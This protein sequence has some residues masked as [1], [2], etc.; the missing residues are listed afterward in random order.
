MWGRRRAPPPREVDPAERRAALK[1]KIEEVGAL[2]EEEK[3]SAASGGSAEGHGDRTVQRT[4]SG[5]A[6][7]TGLS[8]RC[9]VRFCASDSDAAGSGDKGGPVV[10]GSAAGT[11]GNGVKASDAPRDTTAA[12]GSGSGAD[13]VLVLIGTS[14]DA[15]VQGRV[16]RISEI[17]NTAYS[18]VGKHK[19]LD[20]YDVM[21]RLEMGDAGVRANRVLHLAYKGDLL[22]GCASS[23][24]SPGWTGEGCGHW[25]LLAVDPAHQGAGIA[26]ALV[27]AA[28]RRLATTC[29]AIQIEYQH[30]EGDEFSHRLM[31]WYE[32]KLGFDGG[33]R[34]QRPGTTSFRRCVK[35]IPE[36]EQ[37]RGRQ[38]RLEEFHKWLVEQLIEA[39]GSPTEGGAAALEKKTSSVSASTAS[40]MSIAARGDRGSNGERE[41]DDEDSD[42]AMPGDSSASEASSSSD[43]APPPQPAS[44]RPPP[45]RAAW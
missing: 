5:R 26:T 8:E 25:G 31:R 2:L 22:V 20:T 6:I 10:A 35:P 28:E 11:G 23:T 17:V 16:Q 42:E 21:D 34:R 29:E 43:E 9:L 41:E 33:P 32:D 24:F 40:P 1:R 44:D 4:G 14:Q 18:S 7:A 38:R 15:Q 12:G 37:K 3:A 27:L 13:E 45:P 30:T 19:R 36:E 39:G